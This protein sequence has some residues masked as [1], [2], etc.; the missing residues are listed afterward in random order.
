MGIIPE[1]GGRK[2]RTNLLIRGVWAGLVFCKAPRPRSAADKPAAV[3]NGEAIPTSE[4]EAVL[5]LRPQELFRSLTPAE[6]HP[7][8]GARV[9]ISEK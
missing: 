5:A 6:A 8:G 4:V 9:L 3:V 1:G 7:P 2:C